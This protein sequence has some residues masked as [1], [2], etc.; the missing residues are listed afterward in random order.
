MP[1]YR[2]TS[3]EITGTNGHTP[4]SKRVWARNPANAA[5]RAPVIGRSKRIVKIVP[6]Y[7]D[8]DELTYYFQATTENNDSFQIVVQEEINLS[9]TRIFFK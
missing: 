5:R 8:P 7:V 3:G 6:V 4:K 1:R 2:V 9:I